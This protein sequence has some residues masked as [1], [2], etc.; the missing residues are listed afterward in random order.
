MGKLIL[1]LLICVNTYAISVKERK[2]LD[3]IAYAEGTNE[4]YNITYC[5][6]TFNSYDR[7]PKTVVCCGG[8]C[9][10]ASGRYQFL[11]RTWSE[12]SNKYGF[13]DFTPE[14]QD[15]A[16]I[17][18]VK[19]KFV[20]PDNISTYSS[21]KEAIYKLNKIWASFEG[22]PYGQRT[23]TVEQLWRKWSE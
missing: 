16:A 15:K 14:T 12:L 7:H 23:R 17:K 18:L 22:S 5:Y 11:Y 19:S 4:K 9:S 8:Y 1:M 10:S 21:F 2:F 13:K 20:E 3:V 6:K